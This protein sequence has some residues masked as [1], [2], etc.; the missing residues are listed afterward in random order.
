MNIQIIWTE[1]CI[2]NHYGLNVSLKGLILVWNK[3]IFQ[4]MFKIKFKETKNCVNLILLA[5]FRTNY[6]FNWIESSCARLHCTV[7][8]LIFTQ[9]MPID[10]TRKRLLANFHKLFCCFNI[11]THRN[12]N[13]ALYFGNF[14]WFLSLHLSHYI[15]LYSAGPAPFTFS[16]WYL[17]TVFNSVS[18]VR[19]V[20]FNQFV[21]SRFSFMSWNCRC[22][23]FGKGKTFKLFNTEK[24]CLWN[25][26]SNKMEH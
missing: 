12:W 26:T 5:Y 4:Q 23:N 14:R 13:L 22:E 11:N 2:A 9:R 21:H 6:H 17:F 8:I 10:S 18:I 15:V 7:Y 3:Y 24:K 25:S 20:L 19:F 1:F 16:C